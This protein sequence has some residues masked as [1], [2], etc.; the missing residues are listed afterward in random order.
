MGNK[1]KHFWKMISDKSYRDYDRGL[2]FSKINEYDKAIKCFDKVLKK[3]PENSDVHSAK[4]SVFYRRGWFDKA[5]KCYD[6]AI[7]LDKNNELA[8]HNKGLIFHR[9]RKYK[10]ALENFDKAI[11]LNPNYYN[12]WDH[13]SSIYRKQKKYLEAIECIKQTIRIH[14]EDLDNYYE[15]ACIFA[16]Q[17]KQKNKKAN[18][19]KIIEILKNLISKNYFQEE[20]NKK[21]F[22]EDNDFIFY[23]KD[24]E[25]EKILKNIK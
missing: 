20:E 23:K 12:A 19:K 4:G 11:S 9:E 13:K 18:K 15:L 5:L 16:L 21:D 22:L 14:P 7:K 10:K 3:H 17:D 24:K 6:K 8:Y 25:F 1:I 2:R